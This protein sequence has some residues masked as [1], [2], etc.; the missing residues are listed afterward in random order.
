MYGD[1]NENL[2]RFHTIINESKDQKMVI[3]G[4]HF[5]WLKWPQIKK[6]IYP[7]IYM[8]IPSYKL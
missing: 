1:M 7:S 6:W 4:A 2:F 5:G 8:D 3:I